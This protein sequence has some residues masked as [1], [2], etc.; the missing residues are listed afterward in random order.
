MD[1]AVVH[2]AEG[3]HRRRGFEPDA[4]GRTPEIRPTLGCLGGMLDAHRQMEPVE[5]M[6]GRIDTRCFSERTRPVG[7]VAQPAASPGEDTRPFL[8]RRRAFGLSDY[9]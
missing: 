6:V 9:A 3:G 5:D 2:L 7:A 1:E 4:G 8:A